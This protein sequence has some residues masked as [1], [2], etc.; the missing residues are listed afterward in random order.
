MHERPFGDTKGGIAL[1]FASMGPSA[2]LGI[3]AARSRPP[4]ASTCVHD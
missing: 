3:S 2:S 4:I 1:R